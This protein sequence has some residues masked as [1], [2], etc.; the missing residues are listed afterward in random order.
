MG[1]QLSI[2]VIIAPTGVQAIVPE[3]VIAVARAAASRGTA[4]G[5]SNFA[6]KPVEAVVQAN[7][8]TFAQLYWIGDRDQMSARV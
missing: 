4:L 5:I 1:Q 2:P 7:P 3:G 8:K 6:S